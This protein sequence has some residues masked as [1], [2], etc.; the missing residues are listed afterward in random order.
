MKDSVSLERCQ[1]FVN[2]NLQSPSRH[3]TEAH[4]SRQPRAITLSRQTGCGALAVAEKVAQLLQSDVS[5]EAPQWRVFDRN[6]MDKVLEEHQLPSRLAKFLPEDRINEVQDIAD[7]LF[8]LRPGQWTIVEQTA[9][10]I[11]RLVEAG[12]VILIG[13]GTNFITAHQPGVFHVRLVA[14]LEQRI[15]HAH[16]CYGL[17]MSKARTFCMNQDLGRERYVSKYFKA[18]IEDPLHYH[19]TVNTGLMGYDEV[20]KLIVETSTREAVRKI[21]STTAT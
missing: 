13:R 15:Q 10:T 16:E 8:G 9:E 19:L 14:P 3:F 20:A 2:C 6:L 1:T 12:N 7:E 21:A 17:T 4:A 5:P 11:R 18:D